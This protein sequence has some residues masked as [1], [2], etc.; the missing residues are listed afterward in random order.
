MNPPL[1]DP[2][3]APDRP[4]PET[5]AKHAA[6]EDW[7]RHAGGVAVAYSGGADSAFV[8]KVAH[9]VLGERSVGVT[10]VSASLPRAEREG[11]AATAAAIGARHVL[12]ESHEVED[13]RY[14][15]NTSARC[16]YCKSDVY[17]RILAFA[18]RE[19]FAVVADGTNVDDLSDHRPGRIAARERGVRS[20]LAETGLGKEEVRSLSR[21]LGLP[22]WDKPAAACLSSRV[23]HGIAVTSGLLGRIERGEELLRAIGLRQFRLRH[24][25]SIARIEVEPADLAHVLAHREALVVE[26]KKL[27]YAFV[28]IDLEGF[29]SGSL[30]PQPPERP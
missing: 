15:E 3:L 19:G 6:L 8:L 25:E 20:P 26:L 13:P 14:R 10:A 21:A 1:R 4:S 23:P 27:G 30:N 12:I 29:R 11:A 18:E 16:Y 7:F 24:H 28:T 2:V 9:D 22:T 17:T 5:L